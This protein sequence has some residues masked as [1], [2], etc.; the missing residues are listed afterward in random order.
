MNFIIHE[1]PAYL[2]HL[3]IQLSPGEIPEHPVKKI[4]QLLL[5]GLPPAIMVEDA[6][7]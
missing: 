6:V 5:K 2:C 7:C 4:R 1:K 3:F